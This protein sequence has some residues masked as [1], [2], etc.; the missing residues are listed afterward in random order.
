MGSPPNK[1]RYVTDFNDRHKR[2]WYY[3]RYRGQKFKL[4]GKPGSSEFMAAYA[5]YLA[6][7][8]SG[9]LGRDDNLAYIKGSIGWVIERFLDSDVGFKTEAR[10]SAQ[11][12]SLA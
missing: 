11:L 9:E 4:P 8:E 5:R 12:S 10:H 1:L 2:R 6:A 7:V 3:F